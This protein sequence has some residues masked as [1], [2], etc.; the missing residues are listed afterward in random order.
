[1]AHKYFVECRLCHLWRDFCAAGGA[2]QRLCTLLGLLM[3]EFPD[4]AMAGLQEMDDDGLSA[5][6]AQEGLS[7]S[8]IGATPLKF[9]SMGWR[10]DGAGDGSCTS[11]GIANEQACTILNNS[12]LSGYDSA[13]R[14]NSRLDMG[15]SVADDNSSMGIS[16][17]WQSENGKP[18]ILVLDGLTLKTPAKDY[19]ASG[20]NSSIG[21]I[22][23]FSKGRLELANSNGL[24]NASDTTAHF[25]F[26]SQGDLVYLQGWTG[27]SLSFGNFNFAA[28]FS[29][30]AAGGQLD[31]PGM[32]AVD[33]MG[34]LLKAP[35][36]DIDLL[37]DL[38]YKQD[39][40]A[41]GDYLLGRDPII[42]FGWTGGL[43]N[44]KF[45]VRPGGIGYGTYTSTAQHPSGA[46]HTY[47]NATYY[48]TQLSG[49]SPSLLSEG[50][51]MLA[52][53]D[54]DS[55]F[56]WVLGQAAG[57]HTRALFS[58]WRAMTGSIGPML[59][60]P[61]TFDV[62]QNGQGPGVCF[63]GGFTSGTASPGSC[64]AYV[65]SDLPGAGEAA[66]A[67][68]IR[69]GHLRAFNQTIQ[70]V[71]DVNAIG[72][73]L[74]WSL[75]YTYGK[76]DANIYLTPEGR[77]QGT[78][79]S[80]T[81]TGIKADITLEAQSP[82]YWSAASSSSAAT[83][84]SASSV[85]LGWQ[86][87]THFMIADTRVGGTGSHAAGTSAQY[88]VGLMN[89]DLFWRARNM[90]L[91]VTAGDPGYPLIPGGFWMQADKRADN[92]YGG[93]A[94]QYFFRGMFG[95]GN[96]RDLSSPVQLGLL[97]IDLLAE[98]FLFALTPHA[99]INGD[100]PVG[101]TGLIDL[102]NLGDL[103]LLTF[104]EPSS[105]GSSFSI[106]GV[107]GRVAWANGTV[108]LVSAANNPP[109]NMPKVTISNDLLFGK[110]ADF[111]DGGGAPLVSKIGFGSEYF[112][113]TVLPAGAWH[114]DFSLK[115]P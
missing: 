82:G 97:N 28:R 63:D 19:S 27:P 70:I 33:K 65:N 35:Y 39:A 89:A 60:M 92:D 104:A 32:V 88:G 59:Y 29:N 34:L 53:W 105:P 45:R 64:P 3:L 8:Q 17:D 21:T 41:G 16:I 106:Y 24:F 83:R 75:L 76:L 44:P 37:F 7:L 4:V 111:G 96:L 55:D 67:L 62:V 10:T 103:P 51:N 114:S 58:S 31:A 5:V 36:A 9:G 56:T 25:D 68:L 12:F 52:S 78:A 23:L 61:V 91:R 93:L 115:I 22:G 86:N 54:F 69:D 26:S 80:T 42:R 20:S 108:N 1:M 38:M 94:V 50:M 49:T 71:D 14:I 84:A 74:D 79:L 110:T 77:G 57:D 85:G 113:R 11:G 98:R 87:N 43:V 99:A 40:A 107:S 18:L 66:F 90:Y 102:M 13:F 46:S 72:T 30:G 112:G 100:A 47:D 73:M 48:D 2:R 6:I 15:G 95:G 101:F 81:T 109:T